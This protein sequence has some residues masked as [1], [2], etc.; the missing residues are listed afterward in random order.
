MHLVRFVGPLATLLISAAWAS[1]L[2]GDDALDE[3]GRA[4]ADVRALALASGDP[5][6]SEQIGARLRDAEEQ[7]LRLDAAR[8]ALV[9]HAALLEGEALSCPHPEGRALRSRLE[10]ALVAPP[11]ALPRAVSPPDLARIRSAVKAASFSADKL[12]TLQ[13]AARG[14]HFTARQIRDVMG[15]FDFGKD[16]VQA[17]ALLRPLVVDPENWFEVYGALSFESDKRALRRLIGD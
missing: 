1:P 7:L 16:K 12:E 15:W 10:P 6:A 14:R 8:F 17:A 13:S 4:I 5:S 3:L 9:D 11:P 2:P